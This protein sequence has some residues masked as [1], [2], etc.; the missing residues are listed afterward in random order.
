ML[1]TERLDIVAPILPAEPNPAVVINCAGTAG[2][3]AIVCEKPICCRLSEADE[4]VDACER[5]AVHF[6]AGD[7]WR[8]L[9]AVWEA[10]RLIDGGAIGEVRVQVF[11]ATQCPAAH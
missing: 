8:N 6:A 7:A 1:R 4:M 10:K 11:V 3:R 2:L 5:S 9:A